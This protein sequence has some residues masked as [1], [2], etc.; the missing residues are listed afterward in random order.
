[1]IYVII[2]AKKIPRTVHKNDFVQRLNC[3]IVLANKIHFKPLKFDLLLHST[4]HVCIQWDYLSIF[5]CHF[6][7]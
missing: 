6:L 7:F 2:E 3:A 5:I 4:L 1:M